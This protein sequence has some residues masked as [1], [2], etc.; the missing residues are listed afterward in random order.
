MQKIKQLYRSSYMGE[1]V[2]T[3]MTYTCSHSNHYQHCNGGLDHTQ[4]N[5]GSMPTHSALA[6]TVNPLCWAAWVQRVP[7]PTG[8][9]VQSLVVQFVGTTTTVPH[10]T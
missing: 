5:T 8:D 6:A 4:L 2:I 1:D 7:V 9:L 10:R 3:E